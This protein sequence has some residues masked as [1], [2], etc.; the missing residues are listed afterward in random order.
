MCDWFKN[1]V[2]LWRQIGGELIIL[3]FGL[4][5]LSLKNPLEVVEGCCLECGQQLSYSEMNPPGRPRRYM[6][7][8]CYQAQVDATRDGECLLCGKSLP[9]RQYQ[10]LMQNPRELKNAFCQEQCLDYHKMLA[11]LVLGVPFNLEGL[12]RL[13]VP[14]RAYPAQAEQRRISHNQNDHVIDGKLRRSL[15]LPGGKRR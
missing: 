7:Q 3:I 12:D 11:G 4:K 13:P 2:D 8:R 6:C 15:P 5:Y 10:R 14:R 9:P 1:A